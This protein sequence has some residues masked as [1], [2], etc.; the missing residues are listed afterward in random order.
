MLAPL[1]VFNDR[2]GG[3]S[4]QQQRKPSRPSDSPLQQVQ[5]A[6]LPN[7]ASGPYLAPPGRVQRSDSLL[8]RVFP[9]N[10]DNEST[11]HGH[12]S[13]SAQSLP[14]VSADSVSHSHATPKTSWIPN[15]PQMSP[16]EH[17]FGMAGQR[18]TLSSTVHQAETPGL[19]IHIDAPAPD[20]YVQT[21]IF[22]TPPS[23]PPFQPA[24][25]PSDASPYS[26]PMPILTSPPAPPTVADDGYMISPTSDFDLASPVARDPVS[27]SRPTRPRLDSRD[28]S[29]N[30]LKRSSARFYARDSL[31]SSRRQSLP[32]DTA[33]DTRVPVPEFSRQRDSGS[34]PSSSAQTSSPR[35]YST[36]VAPPPGPTYRSSPPRHGGPSY[37]SSSRP[38]TVHQERI[39][40]D[41]ESYSNITQP[42]YSGTRMSLKFPAPLAPHPSITSMTS[43]DSSRY[44][45]F[46][47]P[48]RAPPQPQRHRQH[49]QQQR[50]RPAS[51]GMPPHGYPNAHAAASPH[52]SSTN[53]RPNMNMPP[54]DFALPS[55][56]YRPPL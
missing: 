18:S 44:P 30:G 45:A 47:N 6:G 34:R 25:I 3:S 22:S 42:S 37:Q 53:S 16:Q 15:T 24:S 39:S 4:Q 31:P 51:R 17:S 8:G 43:E 48:P 41:V 32:V 55:H 28:S 38:L 46:P 21:D 23:P 10:T 7:T 11:E 29:S 49:Q 9:C 20:P 27:S 2:R 50:A 35:R 13:D 40:Q 12:A 19:K 14:S 56:S 33:Y 26:L 36:P 5:H 1:S 52:L 54:N